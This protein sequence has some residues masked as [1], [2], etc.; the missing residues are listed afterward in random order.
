MLGVGAGCYVR[1]LV[2]RLLGTVDGDGPEDDP[3]GPLWEVLDEDEGHEGADDDE[4]GLLQLQGA[5]PMDAD[6]P[7]RPEVPDQD[8][9]RG[10]V[11]RQVIVLE[12]LPDRGDRETQ[13][14]RYRQLTPGTG[15]SPRVQ[16]THPG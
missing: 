12:Q 15:N 7:H 14:L 1:A 2:A 9:H 4:V 16:A 5:L 6:H 13:R 11:H 8:P 10:E 3:G